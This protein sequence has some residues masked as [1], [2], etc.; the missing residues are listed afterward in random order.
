[1]RKRIVLIFFTLTIFIPY[2]SHAGIYRVK[3]GDNLTKI[4]SRYNITVRELMSLNGL[5]GELIKVG[6]KIKVP[7]IQNSEFS[8]SS[9]SRKDST[10]TNTEVVFKV[11]R[12]I[13]VG[14]KVKSGDTLLGLAR[15]F[16]TSVRELKRIN[17]LKTDTIVIGHVLK[18]PSYK[19]EEVR[20][21]RV[22]IAIDTNVCAEA[23]AFDTRPFQLVQIAKEYQ[24]IPYKRGG[25]S[26]Y[27][28]DC[29]GFV[30]MLFKCFDILLPRT[31]RNQFEIG[32]KVK[33]ITVG[34]LLFFATR[35]SS[36]VNHVGI[37]IGDGKFIHASSAEG[38]VVISP[39]S[40]YYKNRFRGARR[41]WELFA[42][43]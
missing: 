23:E 9:A 26:P 37:Y 6:Q 25:E 12:R 2:I 10:T 1:M 14:Y 16:H 18:A 43:E 8:T 33:T 30:R 24:G 15:R 34:D 32:E 4:A 21:P 13:L 41:V 17:S 11:P 31:S 22:D 38:K 40:S 20:L 39:I 28:V 7:D 3:P 5:R 29:S 19:M 27:R 42:Q 35:G 36:R